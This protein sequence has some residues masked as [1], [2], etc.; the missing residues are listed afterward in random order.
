MN[1]K[2]TT[3]YCDP[4]TCLR[5]RSTLQHLGIPDDRRTYRCLARISLPEGIRCEKPVR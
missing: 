2:N 4:S 5:Y 3:E 1:G